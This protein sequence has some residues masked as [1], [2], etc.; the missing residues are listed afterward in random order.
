MTESV[1]VGGPDDGVVLSQFL[2]GYAPFDTLA[3]DERERVADAA[4]LVRVADGCEIIDA[5]TAP[6]QALYVVVRGAVDIWTEVDLTD[7][8]PDERLGV[9]GVFGFS[10]LL[11][12]QSVGPRAVAVAPTTIARI[13]ADLAR[14][15]L[16]SVSGARFLA[17]QGERRSSP[18]PYLTVDDLIVSE[19]LIVPPSTTLADVARQ[20]TDGDVAYAAV[21]TARSGIAA[22]ARDPDGRY[23]LI[24]DAILRRAV[25]VDDRPASTPV[26]DVMA[27]PTPTTLL[28]E[29]AAQ[30]LITLFDTHAD[31]LLVTD[32][33]GRLCGAV[34]QADF[35]VSPSTATVALRQQVVQ[36]RDADELV[37]LGHRAA[38]MVVD[39]L[40][41]GLATSKV[42][43]VYSATID[44]VVRRALVLTFA[45]HPDLGVD[46]FTWL[47]L[48]SNGR[49][50]AV[51]SSDVDSAVAFD[52]S[53]TPADQDRY[54]AV[55]AEVDALLERAGF[56]I[57]GHG[58]TAARPAFS[59]TNAD[60]R[61]AARRWLD[62]PVADQGAI[63]TSL[64][65]DGRPIHGDPGLSAVSQVFGDLRR[66]PGTM[67]LLLQES[68][69]RRARLRSVRDVVARR[70]GTFD[71]KTHALTPVV[72]IARFVA[73]STGNPEGSTV[74]R[75]RAAAGSAMLPDDQAGV[76]V[77]VFEALQRTRLR[78]QIAQRR[79]GAEPRDIVTMRA[80]SP[81][82][83]SVVSQAVREVSGVQRR[84]ENLAHYVPTDEWSSTERT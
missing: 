12:Q 17:E 71:L 33:S 81:I 25:L 41:R 32:D 38:S 58:A 2:A 77:D 82:D 66:H 16:A 54:R 6:T 61:E 74:E 14:T 72:N 29:S 69:S 10:A 57:D 46:A 44:A 47:A 64:L 53:L 42:L 80:L 84:M 56:G 51:L 18:G 27:R 83:R 50:E 21:D 43:A 55:F 70:G 35:A 3:V 7:D 79:R 63:M 67:K 39:L 78:L 20:M 68:L 4:D 49:R 31:Y 75:L 13:P 5:F 22:H 76:L 36:A 37:E 9:G 65:V 15:A 48:G 60:W 23:G 40:A 28:G 1:N 34:D 62:D 11:T 8:R 19:P 52:D 45:E 73:L 26:A 30:A 59:R 24:T